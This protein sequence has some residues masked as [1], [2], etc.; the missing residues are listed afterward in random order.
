M[1]PMI[2]TLLICIALFASIASAQTIENDIESLLTT[3][4]AVII[5]PPTVKN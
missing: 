5:E 1:K 2:K 3:E 4:G